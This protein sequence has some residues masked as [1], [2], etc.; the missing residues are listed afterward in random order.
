MAARF[1][2]SRLVPLVLLI[3]PSVFF[4]ISTFLAE[5]ALI[6]PKIRL[7]KIR[8]FSWSAKLAAVFRAIYMGAWCGTHEVMPRCMRARK[9]LD[10]GPVLSASSVGSFG[11]SG[12]YGWVPWWLGMLH[13]GVW[14]MLHIVA[15]YLHA[16]HTSAAIW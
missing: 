14:L 9:A 1:G 4:N 13:I 2:V 10:C 5:I 6:Y 7:M 12:L 15:P 3:F 8:P 11:L 16:G